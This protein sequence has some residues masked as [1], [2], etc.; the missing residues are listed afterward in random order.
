MT[1]ALL[2]YPPPYNPAYEAETDA[3]ATM[4]WLEWEMAEIARQANGA[5]WLAVTLDE[6]DQA[7]AAEEVMLIAER[8]WDRYGELRDRL[9][10]M[11]DE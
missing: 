2:H 7:D 6:C 9:R 5:A 3:S 8:L 1:D 4:D 10:E 11:E